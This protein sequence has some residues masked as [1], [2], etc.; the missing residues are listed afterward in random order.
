LCATRRENTDEERKKKSRRRQP[1]IPDLTTAQTALHPA[2]TVTP[3]PFDSTCGNNNYSVIFC[4]EGRRTFREGEERMKG[5]G[6]TSGA[7]LEE[8]LTEKRSRILF[9]TSHR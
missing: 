6:E 7:E 8:K 5:V 4:G 3:T 1:S 2:L 9:V